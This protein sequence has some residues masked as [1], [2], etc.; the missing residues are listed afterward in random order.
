MLL[1]YVVKVMTLS[2]LYLLLQGRT[3]SIIVLLH[4]GFDFSR[5]A[6]FTPPPS[7]KVINE[8]FIYLM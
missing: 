7:L 5:K 2:D 3:I 1:T 4:M 8:T 6:T